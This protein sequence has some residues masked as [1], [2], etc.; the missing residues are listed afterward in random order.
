M[1]LLA[2]MQNGFAI[3]SWDE[4]NSKL[5]SVLDYPHQKVLGYGASWSIDE[6]NLVATGSFYDKSLHLWRCTL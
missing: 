3:V 5:S 6:E 1:A 2:C 4:C